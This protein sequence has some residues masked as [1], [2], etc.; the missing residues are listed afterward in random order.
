M[1]KLSLL[2]ALL[3]I[4]TIGGVYATWTYVGN[5]QIHTF[6]PKG[7]IME[8]VEIEGTVGSYTIESNFVQG[9]IDQAK[10]ADTDPSKYYKAVLDYELK[11]G[12]TYAK[13]TF[14]FTPNATAGKDIQ[15]KG[16]TTYLWFGD[17][18]MTYKTDGEGNYNAEGTAHNIFS[19][20]Y[21]TEN[22]ITIHPMGT[23]I[24]LMDATRN[25]VW[26]YD[27]VNKVFYFTFIDEANDI[28]SMESVFTL[29]DF[30][31]DVESE[32]AAFKTA[33]NGFI[34]TVVSNK[35]PSQT[36]LPE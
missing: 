19:F 6:S 7:V 1:K 28:R 5:D 18:G 26:E 15:T 11:A 34:R 30:V 22:Y 10:G 25:F 4:A 14:K 23:D 35:V 8:D 36:V 20:T 29:N 13:V 33:I 9:R 27:N 3:L 2:V 12:D 17:S 21:H 31:L 24:S 16:V 32:Y